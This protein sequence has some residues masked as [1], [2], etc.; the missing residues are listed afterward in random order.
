MTKLS[1]IWSTWSRRR[2]VASPGRAWRAR[3]LLAQVGDPQE[4]FA[5][6]HVTGSSG[7]GSTAAMAAAILR[8]AGYRTGIFRSPHLEAYTERIAVD[9]APIAPSDWTRL[10]NRLHPFVERMAGGALPGYTLGRPALLQVLWPMAALYFAERGVE[11]AVVK[12][13]MGGHR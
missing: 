6:L 11:G 7:K 4:R 12:V 5:T 13:G 3:M 9:G 1:P 10:L 2:C 8:A